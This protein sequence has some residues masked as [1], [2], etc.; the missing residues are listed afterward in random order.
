MK[1]ILIITTALAL[2][3]MPFTVYPQSE[4][5]PAGAPPISQALVPEGDFA[6][7]LAAALKLG[8]PN[9]EP[10][11][12]DMLTSA[13]IAPKNGWIADYPVTPNIIGE[14]QM[15]WRLQQIL[16]SCRWKRMTL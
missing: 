16:R 12:E 1:K 13:G 11:A 10:Q 7:K 5:K 8:S 3:L 9:D 6:L 14:L 15:P 2:L 4:Q